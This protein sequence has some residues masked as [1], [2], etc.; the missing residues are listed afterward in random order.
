MSTHPVAVQRR[1]G[2]RRNAIIVTSSMVVLLGLLLWGALG[3]LQR[4]PSRLPDSV[5]GDTSPNLTFNTPAKNITCQIT[6]DWARCLAANP[7]YPPPIPD[8]PGNA[9]QA[10]VDRTTIHRECATGFEEPKG[11]L[12]YGDDITRDI[13]V[14]QS[15]HAAVRCINTETQHG[16]SVSPHTF[17]DY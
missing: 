3:A 15:R 12:A 14:C 4:P 11:P 10:R 5:A 17:I 13:I 1:R 9:V 6:P 16:F 7:E 2:R 8:C